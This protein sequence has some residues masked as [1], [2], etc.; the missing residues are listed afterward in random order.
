MMAF[1]EGKSYSVVFRDELHNEISKYL[2]NL[3][4][5]DDL[6]FH[7]YKAPARTRITQPV[8]SLFKEHFRS[9]TTFETM[10]HHS[11]GREVDKVKIIYTNS[12]CYNH[13]QF[14]IQFEY[15]QNEYLIRVIILGKNLFGEGIA[16]T[17][18]KL[19]ILDRKNIDESPVFESI[20]SPSSAGVY[21]VEIPKDLIVKE[22]FRNENNSVP[23]IIQ[24]QENNLPWWYMDNT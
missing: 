7:R 21:L 10:H 14:Y 12:F 16:G 6:M 5:Y 3:L 18:F 23:F 11:E 22:R 24:R 17:K 19:R 15:E 8:G 13:H 2:R 1:P 20:E 9:D 4:C